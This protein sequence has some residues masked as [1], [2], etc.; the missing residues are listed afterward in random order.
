MAR[1]KYG[2]SP[3]G[4]WFIDVLESYDVGERLGRGKSYANTGKVLSLEIEGGAITAK[5]SGHYS[6]FYKIKIEFPPLPESQK[7]YLLSIIKNSPALL[8]E[9]SSGSLSAAFLAELKS[10]SIHLIPQNWQDMKKQCSCPDSVITCKHIAAVYYALSR[11]IDADPYIL[12]TLRGID[13]KKIADEYGTVFEFKLQE[14]FAI[15]TISA[16]SLSPQPCTTTST[17]TIN[18]SELPA[19]FELISALLPPSPPFSNERDFSILISEFYHTAMR[20]KF[21]IANHVDD[22]SGETEHTASRSKWHIECDPAN[23]FDEVYLIQETLQG[24][25]VKQTPYEAFEQFCFYSMPDGTNSYTFLYYVFKFLNLIVQAQLYY[26]YPILKNKELKIIWLM[27]KNNEQIK[28]TL[29]T[30]SKIECGLLML[31][32]N[33]LFADGDSVI[34]IIATHVLIEYVKRLCFVPQ[35][36]SIKLFELCNMFFQGSVLDTDSPTLRSMPASIY[37]WIAPLNIDFSVYEYTISLKEKKGST[38]DI[39][40]CISMDVTINDKKVP[41]KDAAKKTSSLEVLK[42]VTALSNYLPQLRILCDKKEVVL[43]EDVLVKFLDEAGNLLSSLGIQVIFPKNLHRELKPRLILKTDVKSK[44]A[45]NLTSY[46]DLSALLEFKWQ[47]AI[48]G[49]VLTEQEFA[50]IVKQKKAVVKFKDQYI[51]IDP[52][53]LA[54]L[55]KQTQLKKNNINTA[56]DFLKTYF[57]GDTLLSFDA[58]KVIEK[59]FTEHNFNVPKQ[60]NASLRTYQLRGFNWLLSLLYTGFGCILADDMGLGKTVQTIAVILHLHES[61]L[62]KNKC[63]IVA[64]AALLENWFMELQKFA[65]NLKVN[66]YHGKGRKFLKSNDIFLTTYQTAV[67]D[68]TKMIDAAFSMLVLDEAHLIKNADTRSAKSIKEIHS[69]YK[70]ALSGTPVENRL[71]DM[72]SIFDFIIPGYLGTSAEFRDNFRIPIEVMRNKEKA[73]ELQKITS[74]FLLR[75]L[76]TDKTIISDLPEKITTNEYSYLEKEQ[77]AL[78]ESVIKDNLDKLDRLDRLDNT[79]N[80]KSI[81]S[82]MILTL[83]TSLK[84]I[85]NHPRVYDKESPAISALSGK[86]TL[87]LALL[88]DILKSG[89]K[90]LIF[91]QYVET[92]ECLQKIIHNEAG[93]AALMYHGGLTQGKRSEIVND[94]Q[95]D[96][97]YKIM[98]I[99]L[100]AGGL[101]LNLTAANRVIHYDLWYNPAVEAQATDRVFRIGQKQNVFVH[102]FI[103]KNTF[104]EKIDAIISSKKELAE[105][106]LQ[107]GESW[108]N[109]M[110]Q[111][112][113]RDLFTLSRSAF[114]NLNDSSVP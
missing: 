12:F 68:K 48:G 81:R 87:L 77:A 93:E 99:S 79:N 21:W 9:I 64:P 24:N 63:L 74:P 50:A 89:E 10:K 56:Q 104:E 6:P 90:V 4:S 84:Q 20:N 101:G 52:Q 114:T 41:L 61:G 67:R 105:M 25:I 66:K 78:Y 92:L 97:A 19:S 33:E 70:I 17:E 100:R 27:F 109:K 58:E 76:K 45:V 11:E 113:L 31:K 86:C 36:G 112:E 107:T 29:S 80:Q 65:P 35:N 60:L 85:C 73:Q 34:E 3:W 1:Q 72:R 69:T 30:I 59:I 57:A 8:C 16:N 32:K 39:E 53:E 18:M 103:T 106:S 42:P 82:A 26:P 83:L 51:R 75:R 28:T 43:S 71:E 62:L 23:P 2:I 91:S 95:T 110:S 14:P 108:L 111:E 55:F 37:R 22:F 38:A 88:D 47:I 5:V 15:K 96:P 40:F 49:N 54:L 46:L 98:L 94:F 102:R 44:K 13:L 7:D